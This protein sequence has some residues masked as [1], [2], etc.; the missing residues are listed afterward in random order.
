MCEKLAAKSYN[1]PWDGLSHPLFLNYLNQTFEFESSDVSPFSSPPPLFPLSSI[2]IS[3]A[4]TPSGGDVRFGGGE[5]VGRSPW[6]VSIF[7]LLYTHLI[8]IILI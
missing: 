6:T 8:L 1:I 7:I 2:L 5:G 4:G 3:A